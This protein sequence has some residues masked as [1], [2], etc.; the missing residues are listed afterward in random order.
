[1]VYSWYSLVGTTYTGCRI[2]FFGMR[3]GDE[4]DDLSQA[5][6]RF[7]TKALPCDSGLD[8]S[9]AKRTTLTEVG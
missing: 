4:V 9:E 3:V 7:A 8:A 5:N 6:R 2:I 1:M